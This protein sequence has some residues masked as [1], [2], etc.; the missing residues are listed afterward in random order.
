[1]GPLASITVLANL[2]DE[3]ATV[4]C[5]KYCEGATMQEIA[6]LEQTTTGAISSR[7]ARARH[8]FRKAF[9]NTAGDLTYDTSSEKPR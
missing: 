3:Y 2:P 4:L 6:N 7:L 8:A 9:G 5:A 1:M